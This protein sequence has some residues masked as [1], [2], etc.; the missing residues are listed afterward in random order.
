M[1]VRNKI[2]APDC[3]KLSVALHR[4]K[5]FHPKLL[6][7]S[8]VQHLIQLMYQMSTVREQREYKN[9]FELDV[10]L[11]QYIN[12]CLNTFAYDKLFDDQYRQFLD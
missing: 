4:S 9:F 12:G 11:N 10:F 7:E 6:V 1:S 5:T 8:S 3:T 2:V